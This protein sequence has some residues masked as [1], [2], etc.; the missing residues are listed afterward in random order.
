MRSQFCF[1]LSD[2]SFLV[3]SAASFSSLWFFSVG[4]FGGFV[5]LLFL[6]FYL[7]SL[8]SWSSLMDVT[9]HS[10]AHQ[11]QAYNSCL[12]F[13]LISQTHTSNYLLILTRDY[14][15]D[16]SKSMYSE[17]PIFLPPLQ[18]ISHWQISSCQVVIAPSL[19]MFRPEPWDHPWPFSYAS[20]PICRKILPLPANISVIWTLLPVSAATSLIQV[21]IISFNNNYNNCLNGLVWF[22]LV[23]FLYSLRDVIQSN[24]I[25]C[26]SNS[27]VFC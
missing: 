17:Q 6:I 14:I 26:K 5:H 15:L 11:P 13:C 18:P 25:K 4:V 19:K 9:F 20:H 3:S 12:H 2:C 21:T 10:S 27:V 16:V 24:V 7:N 22:G 23:A 1:Y 8:P